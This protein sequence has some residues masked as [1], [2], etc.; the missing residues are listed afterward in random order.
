MI[1]MKNAFTVHPG[2]SY[3]VGTPV[4]VVE[5]VETL[6]GTTYPGRARLVSDPSVEFTIWAGDLVEDRDGA[7]I[8][9]RLNDQY[10]KQGGAR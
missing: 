1:R 2:E 7:T 6:D 4:E 10:R 8:G 9:E 5:P 3:P